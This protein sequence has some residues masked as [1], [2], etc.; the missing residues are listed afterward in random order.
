MAIE[1]RFGLL[2]DY[3]APGNRGKLTIVHVFNRFSPRPDSIGSPIGGGVLVAYL[4]CSLADGTDHTLTIRILT[5][6]E[7]PLDAQI[8]IEGLQ[9]AST[10]PGLPLSAQI[11]LPIGQLPMPDYGDYAFD[12]VVDGTS[13]GR[14]PFYVQ[15]PLPTAPPSPPVA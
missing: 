10:G 6:D 3:A 1:M 7:D 14:I 11:L 9:L 13:V 5:A 4:E 8:Q 15:A 12:I 2:A